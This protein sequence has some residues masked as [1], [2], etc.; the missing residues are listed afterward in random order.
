MV[1]ECIDGP[2]IEP[3]IPTLPGD[4]DRLTGLLLLL[5]PCDD[6]DDLIGTAPGAD[7]SVLD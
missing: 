1:P 6:D 2:P 7:A 5:E 3:P 4:M